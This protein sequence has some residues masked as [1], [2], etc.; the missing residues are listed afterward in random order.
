V[1]LGACYML[2]L[3]RRVMF[4][5]LTK[6]SLKK[7]L[8]LSPREMAVFAPLIILVLWMGVY[9]TP[10]LDVMHVSVDH[11]MSQMEKGLAAAQMGPV[12]AGQ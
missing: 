10:F 4:G 9:P 2:Y 8:D 1:I 11:L 7:I 5:K 12:L 6:D 3:Y